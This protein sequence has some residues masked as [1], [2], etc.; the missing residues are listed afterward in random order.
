MKKETKKWHKYNK[1]EHLVKDC[2]I[3]QKMKNRS[4]QEDLDEEDDKEKSFVRDSK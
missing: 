3:G 2:R 1:V 4:I